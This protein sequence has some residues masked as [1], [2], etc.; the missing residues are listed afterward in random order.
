MP[1]AGLLPPPSPSYTSEQIFHTYF[2]SPSA[3]RLGLL[4]VCLGGGVLG[5][6]MAVI[7]VQLKRIEGAYSPLAYTDL[8]LGMVTLIVFVLPPMVM[9]TIAFRT[10]R[11]PS[12]MLALQDLA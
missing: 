10:D 3:V 9:Q 1:V 8:G 4:M 12:S 6:W 11:D 5:P 2:D 7:S